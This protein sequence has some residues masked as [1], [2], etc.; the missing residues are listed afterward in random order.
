MIE[1]KPITE[2]HCCPYCDAEIAEST[3]SI[4]GACNVEVFYCPKCQ[5]P[6]PRDKQVCPQCGTAIRT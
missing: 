2:S 6:V 4:C 1:K 3:S 5:Q